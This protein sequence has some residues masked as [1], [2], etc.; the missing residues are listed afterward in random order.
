MEKSDVN[1]YAA[2][3]W[4]CLSGSYQSVRYLLANGSD[5]NAQTHGDKATP[6]LLAMKTMQDT[7]EPRI[8]HKLLLYGADSQYIDI[9]GDSCEAYLLTVIKDEDLKN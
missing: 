4:A 9:N 3:H 2:L 1:G 5:P 6:L 7:K 8:L